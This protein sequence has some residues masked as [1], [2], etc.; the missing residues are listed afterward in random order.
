MRKLHR[1]VVAILVTAFAA[2]IAPGATAAP[3]NLVANG[4]FETGDFTKWTQTGQSAFDGVFCPGPA[5]AGEGNCSAFFGPVGVLGGISQNMTSLTVGNHYQLVFLLAPD[6][7]VPSSFVVSFGGV[8]LD[9]L[10]NPSAT[11]FQ[12]HVYDVVATA[13]TESLAFTF[14]DD[15]G[16]LLFDAVSLVQSAVPEASTLA[17]FGVALVA[18]AANRRRR[19]TTVRV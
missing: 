12:A 5:S 1:I 13:T 16:F 2:S 4:G 8:T 14:R 10:T 9:S 11:P 15:T 3:I 7:G 6:G 19:S 17:L 18:L